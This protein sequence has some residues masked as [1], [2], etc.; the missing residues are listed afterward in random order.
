MQNVEE[1]AH[2]AHAGGEGLLELRAGRDAVVRLLR[3]ARLEHLCGMLRALD[4]A[5]S[6]VHWLSGSLR[7]R[8]PL[9]VFRVTNGAPEYDSE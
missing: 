4:G 9:E 7:R 2:R 1:H 5:F 3:A 6:G 8:V